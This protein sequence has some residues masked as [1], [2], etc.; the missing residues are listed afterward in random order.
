MPSSLHMSEND[1][2]ACPNIPR[3]LVDKFMN[4]VLRYLFSNCFRR[5]RYLISF[6]SALRSRLVSKPT[7]NSIM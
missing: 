6:H 7:V 5:G 2:E 3:E 1:S 4:F